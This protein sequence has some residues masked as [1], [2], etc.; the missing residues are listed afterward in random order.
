MNK[1]PEVN[2]EGVVTMQATFDHEK[3]KRDEIRNAQTFVKADTKVFTRTELLCMKCSQPVGEFDHLSIGVTAGP[4]YCR[5]CGTGHLIKRTEDGVNVS[6][7]KDRI[8]KTLVLLKLAERTKKP[9]HIVVEGRMFVPV[10]KEA[11]EVIS[12]QQ[13]RDKYYY[14][15]HTC[16]VNYLDAHIAVNGDTD[17]HGVFKHV[18]TVI[19]PDADAN[20]R[21]VTMGGF[22]YPDNYLAWIDLFATLQ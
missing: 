13:G 9:I 14:N 6:E 8:V 10:G 4:W 12:E 22:T 7:S 5:F 19:K 1:G 18:Q 2:A 17:P 3:A 15:E 16:P 11:Y 21:I 20:G